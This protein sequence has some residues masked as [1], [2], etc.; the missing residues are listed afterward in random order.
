MKEIATNAFWLPPSFTF[1]IGCFGFVQ[2]IRYFY[3]VLVWTENFV[4]WNQNIPNTKAKYS[5]SKFIKIHLQNGGKVGKNIWLCEDI[6]RV[7][8]AVLKWNNTTNIAAHIDCILTFNALK[9]FILSLWDFKSGG[10]IKIYLS[11]H[12]LSFLYAGYFSVCFPT[13]QKR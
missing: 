5:T 2:H 7:Q 3:F 10:S 6:S 1:N 8:K 9:I 12:T 11:F 13:Q 4:M